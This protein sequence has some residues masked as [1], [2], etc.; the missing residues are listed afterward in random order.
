M[1]ALGMCVAAALG[2]SLAMRESV[3]VWTVAVCVALFGASFVLGRRTSPRALVLFAGGAVLSVVDLTA[4]PVLAAAVVLPW[5]LGYVAQQQAALAAATVERVHLR[6]R[7][8]IAHDIHDTLGHELTLLAVRAGALEMTGDPGQRAA[9]AELR[10]SAG[11]A[12]ERLADLVALLRDSAEL[13]P[14]PVT[15]DDLVERSRQAGMVVTL[16]QDGPPV[17]D[18]TA[19]RVVQ[20]A[21]TNA[22]KHA[23]KSAVCVKVT[24][25]DA[26]VIEV[27]NDTGFRRGPGS[28]VGLI[29]LRERV[30]LAG[31]TL[32]V[33]RGDGRFSLVVTLPHT[34]EQ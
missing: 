22:A 16:E 10:A 24:N 12:T 28:R 23:P 9:V 30:R 29:A 34:G 26:T 33:D 15:I 1:V 21:L 20:E 25:A 11:A 18:R 19:L 17:A 6:E 5:F 32:R 27:G 7:T 8:R 2:V 31:G 4:L 14:V 13:E 3:P